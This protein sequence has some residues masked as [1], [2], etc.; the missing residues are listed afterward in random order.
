ME[1][2]TQLL[3]ALGALVAGALALL[4]SAILGSGLLAVGY[5][6][7]GILIQQV[8]SDRAVRKRLLQ[9]VASD[10]DYNRQLAEGI[11]KNAENKIL[12][13]T[14]NLVP[15]RVVA[16]FELASS[17]ASLRLSDTMRRLV[18]DTI[19][20]AESVNQGLQSLREYRLLPSADPAAITNKGTLTG[21]IQS[22]LWEYSGRYINSANTLRKHIDTI[23]GERER[24][25]TAS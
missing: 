24:S 22:F 21:N 25:A 20:E 16:L 5:V 18:T 14:I 9:A 19:F 13:V 15:L 3:T 12:D 4:W 7:L 11:R 8:V 2:S 1:S 23:R 6:L 10:L 17:S